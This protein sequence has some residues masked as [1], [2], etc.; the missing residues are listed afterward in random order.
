MQPL[1][2]TAEG[3]MHSLLHGLQCL[4]V[5]SIESMFCSRLVRIEIDAAAVKVL[6]PGFK[7]F[8]EKIPRVFRM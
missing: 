2:A 7:G 6:K 4:G 5:E 3:I 1:G 8:A